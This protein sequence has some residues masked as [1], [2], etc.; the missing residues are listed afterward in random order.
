MIWRSKRMCKSRG[1]ALATEPKPRPSDH[2]SRSRSQP[3]TTLNS[4]SSSSATAAAAA[5]TTSSSSSSSRATASSSSSSS[6][7]SLASVRASLPE[8]PII[9]HFREISTATNGFLSPRLSSSS[10]SWRCSLRG[11][12]VVV[13]QRRFLSGDPSTLPTRLSALSRAHHSAIIPLLGASFVSPHLYLVYEYAP[14]ASLSL[15][16]RNPRNPSFTPLSSWSSRV[17]IAADV[18]QGLDY[19][20]QHSPASLNGAAPI[21][22][23]IKSSSIIVSDSDLRARICHFGA[24]A[25]SGEI[26]N[27]S[28]APNTSLIQGTRGYMAPEVIAGG[29][30]SPSS[31]IFA[32][33]VVLLELLS[34]KEAL[35]YNFPTEKMVVER[36]SVI[37]TAR[38][39][40]GAGDEDAD[41]EERS[42]R[43]RRWMDM[44]LRDSFPVASA[45][46]LIRVALRCVAEE[47]TARPGMEWVA[48][49]I[50][51]VLLESK[52]WEKRIQMP[53]DISVSL[54][55]R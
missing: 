38:E 50:S 35:K 45:E 21:H 5:A 8:T 42:G 1:D 54:A 39:T 10:S 26:P 52:E 30:I 13:V 7:T 44:R 12:D 15:L 46:K 22:N 32:F 48:G 23:R 53:T 24:A 33:G 3:S 4:S 41:D 19:I 6:R 17:Q 20:H 18:A 37:E 29:S 43:V 11:R 55:P 47:A 9:Y 27:D 14:G 25:L 34:G 51:K 16:L 31:D 2:I 28:T 36:T 49:K 40:I